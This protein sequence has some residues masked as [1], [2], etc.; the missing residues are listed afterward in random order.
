MAQEILDERVC[1][2]RELLK[3]AYSISQL[4]EIGR[5]LKIAYFDKFL[6]CW[7]IDEDEASME[8]ASK[9]TDD[10]LKQIFQNYKPHERIVFRGKY[11]LLSNG[12]LSLEGAQ[13]LINDGIRKLKSKY[14]SLGI[15]LLK[16]IIERGGV[17]DLDSAREVIGLTKADTDEILSDLENF[18]ILT[19]SYVG[20]K[21]REWSVPKE[22]FS[23][24]DAE[25]MGASKKTP[26]ISKS[27]GAKAG[28]NNKLT[29]YLRREF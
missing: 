1:E 4:F 3:R 27:A 5:W 24:I 25:I 15:L 16:A 28:E 7:E 13:A 12:K 29:P 9:I 19:L 14:G 22:A 26:M 23:I 2:R 11:Y 20:G 10:M 18:G 8:I 6:C 21:Y 17:I